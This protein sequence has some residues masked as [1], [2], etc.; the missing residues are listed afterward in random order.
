MISNNLKTKVMSEFEKVYIGKGR[1]IEG[2][3]IVRVT[4]PLVELQK[5]AYDYEG[6]DYV[7]FEVAK[8]KEIDQ[9]GRSHSCYYSKKVETASKPAAIKAPKVKKNSIGKRSVKTIS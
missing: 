1:K 7:T 2:M 9:F 5:I 6:V 3:D 8:L 4:M